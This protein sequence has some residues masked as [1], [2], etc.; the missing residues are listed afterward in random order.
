MDSFTV[1][2]GV[3]LS[4]DSFTSVTSNSGGS[5]FAFCTGEPC[6][7]DVGAASLFPAGDLAGGASLDLDLA[8]SGALRAHHQELL[9]STRNQQAAA[10]LLPPRS[11]VRSRSAAD[12]LALLQSQQQMN[13]ADAAAREDD[14]DAQIQRLMQL[15]HVLQCQ[16][17]QHAAA[18]AGHPRRASM[19]VEGSAANPAGQQRRSSLFVEGSAAN[20]FLEVERSQLLTLG[21]ANNNASLGGLPVTLSLTPP[22]SHEG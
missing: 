2:S 20:H 12:L 3:D 6:S 14:I 5:V 15:K 9:G 16:K 18:A 22:M 19:I 1:W 11:G 13:D 4:G 17:Q 10:A 8:G 21:G 7:G